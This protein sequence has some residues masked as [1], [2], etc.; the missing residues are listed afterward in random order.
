MLTA[1]PGE[2]CVTIRLV[3][4]M[5]KPCSGVDVTFLLGEQKIGAVAA[6]VGFARIALPT[7][8]LLEVRASFDGQYSS[9]LV[10]PGE[11][12]ST[13]R[14]DDYIAPYRSLVV[15][16]VIWCLQQQHLRAIVVR[17]LGLLVSGNLNIFTVASADGLNISRLLPSGPVAHCPD[18]TS[19]HPCVRCRIGKITVR[20]CA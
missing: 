19:G 6:S 5:G 4:S 1:E 9:S 16:T 17:A 18:G 12:H 13:I 15:R 10:G 20:I 7:D 14:F 3:D 11:T 2:R 8:V